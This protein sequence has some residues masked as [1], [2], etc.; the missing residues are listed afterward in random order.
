MNEWFDSRIANA[1][2]CTIDSVHATDDGALDRIGMILIIIIVLVNLQTNGAA[3]FA[4]PSWNIPVRSGGLDYV[5][6]PL[7]PHFCDDPIP[8]LLRELIRHRLEAKQN[9]LVDATEFSTLR[10]DTRNDDNI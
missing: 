8:K 6:D 9:G 5:N 7:G 2:N 4:G 1:T 10:S 3:V